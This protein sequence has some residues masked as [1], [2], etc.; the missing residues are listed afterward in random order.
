MASKYREDDDVLS[1]NTNHSFDDPGIVHFGERLKKAMNGES[2]MSFAKKCGLSDTVIGKYLRGES[3]PGI[4]KLPSI[5]M[6]CGRSIEWLLTGKD[7][8]TANQ[9][10]KQSKNNE[11]IEWWQI[12]LKSLSEDELEKAVEAFKEGGKNALLPSA[13]R[14]AASKEILCGG[15]EIPESSSTASIETASRNTKR[16]G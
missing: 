8:S 6:A 3:Y 11:L 10:L 4:D 12:I 7:D 2:N 14:S 15:T 16:A 13:I 5:S 1:K 9:S